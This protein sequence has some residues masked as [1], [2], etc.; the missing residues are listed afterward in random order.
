MHPIKGQ[1]YRTYPTNLDDNELIHVRANLSQSC[2]PAFPSV[3]ILFD[4]KSS[5][6]ASAQL[7][8][9]SLPSIPGA[10]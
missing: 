10:I 6:L 9:A 2:Q 5:R 1:K 4:V 3:D 7:H 8:E